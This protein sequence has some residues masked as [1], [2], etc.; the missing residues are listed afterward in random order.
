MNRIAVPP[1]ALNIQHIRGRITR[2][3][4]SCGRRPEEITLLAISKTF[5]CEAIAE[6]MAAE[7]RRFGES[8]VQEAETKIPHFTGA[9][10]PEWHLIGHLQSNKTRRA[11]ELFDVIQSVDSAKLAA[12]ISQAALEL[13]K[14]ISILLQVD[15]G[16]EETK[17]GTPPDEIREIIEAISSLKGVRL[18]GLMTLPPNFENP[19]DAR[20]YFRRLR[21]LGEKLETEQPGCLG[22]RHLSMGMSHDFEAA[23][24]EGATIVRVGTAIFGTR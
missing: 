12:R 6:A 16:D 19:E 3:A 22:K 10:K 17:F 13:G 2:T 7:I 20:P 5:P 18:D 21:E 9:V 14:T 8:R 24:R 15:L 23:I 1:I 11:V 4:E